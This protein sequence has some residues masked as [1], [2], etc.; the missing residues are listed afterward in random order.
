MPSIDRK[1]HFSSVLSLP[2]LLSRKYVRMT[3]RKIPGV[4]RGPCRQ[5]GSQGSSDLCDQSSGSQSA[6]AM[7]TEVSY[8]DEG[9]DD[10]IK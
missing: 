2:R 10:N 6:D 5:G 3:D 7:G 1:V 8:R 4:L 9:A